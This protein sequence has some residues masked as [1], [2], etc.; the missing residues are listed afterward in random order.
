[1]RIVPA[2]GGSPLED[3]TSVVLEELNVKTADYGAAGEA[4]AE[5]RGKAR[6]DVLG[7]RFGKSMKDAARAIQ[8]LD[9]PTLAALERVGSVEI[10]VGGEKHAIHRDEVLVEHDDPEGWVLERESGWSVA[11]DLAIDDDLRRE[12]FAREIVNKIQFMRRKAGFSITDRIHVFVEGTDRLRDAIERHG[13]LIRDETQADGLEFAAGEG[14]AREE[15]NINCEP[16]VLTVR[17][18]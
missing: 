11:L 3:L 7:P 12:G 17:R 8:A 10:D 9:T 4:L 18:T 13:P 15:W 14:E 6:F 2:A 1:V 16:A 5:L